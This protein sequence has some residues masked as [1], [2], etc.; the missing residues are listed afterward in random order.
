[1]VLIPY[2]PNRALATCLLAVVAMCLMQSGLAS[3]QDRDEPDEKNIQ[4]L[5]DRVG[6]VWRRRESARGI[7]LTIFDDHQGWF[8]R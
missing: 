7:D 2:S 5:I 8:R 3:A 1:M 4:S 6:K